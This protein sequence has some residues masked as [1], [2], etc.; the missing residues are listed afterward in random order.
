MRYNQ[1]RHPF[2]EYVWSFAL[3]IY[4]IVVLSLCHLPTIPA[5]NLTDQ[6]LVAGDRG[7]DQVSSKVVNDP[8]AYL[9]YKTGNES[10]PNADPE[11]EFI[12][13]P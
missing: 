8:A 5:G 9:R 10:N 3:K 1:V 4:M 11:H 7:G 6:E 2:T 12:A 13:D